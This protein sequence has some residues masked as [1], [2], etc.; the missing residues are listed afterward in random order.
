LLFKK[1]QRRSEWIHFAAAS[2]ARSS[3]LS[4][5]D[6]MEAAMFGTFLVCLGALAIAIL[7]CAWIGPTGESQQEKIPKP[8]EPEPISLM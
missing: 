7:G 3:I 2:F 5:L 4:E 8:A 6:T 1:P